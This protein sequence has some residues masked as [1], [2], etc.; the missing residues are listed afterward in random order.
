MN[1]QRTQ[2]QFVDYLKMLAKKERLAFDKPE[3]RLKEFEAAF[4][5]AGKVDRRLVRAMKRLHN[6]QRGRHCCRTVLQSVRLVGR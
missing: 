2:K 5:E 1:G 4:G 3:V 6:A